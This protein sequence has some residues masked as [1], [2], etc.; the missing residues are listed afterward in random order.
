MSGKC[1][2]PS[3]TTGNCHARRQLAFDGNV[4][5][6]LSQVAQLKTTFITSI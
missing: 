6:V 1:S 2:Q 4:P 5:T 3:A